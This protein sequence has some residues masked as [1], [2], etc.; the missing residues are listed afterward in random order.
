MLLHEWRTHAERTAWVTGWVGSVF[1]SNTLSSI[2]I[3]AA[4]L[5]F[6]AAQ[7]C[8]CLTW[9]KNIQKLFHYWDSTIGLNDHRWYTVPGLQLKDRTRLAKDFNINVFCTVVACGCD[10]LRVWVAYFVRENNI[11]LFLQQNRKQKTTFG[12][13]SPFERHTWSKRYV[14]KSFSVFIEFYYL[15]S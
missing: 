13:P 2:W 9:T 5:I 14:P 1:H 6:P 11:F 7:V 4:S 10:G 3:W 15:F 12:A 8:D